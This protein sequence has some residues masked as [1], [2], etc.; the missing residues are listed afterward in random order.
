MKS[1]SYTRGDDITYEAM[2]SVCF[3][4]APCPYIPTPLALHIHALAPTYPCSNA[5][6]Y[7]CTHALAYYC[8]FQAHVHAL[9]PMSSCPMRPCLGSPM[10]D[11][12]EPAQAPA[13]PFPFLSLPFPS[14]IP[15][16]NEWSRIM[17]Q[18]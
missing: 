4:S 10:S 1:A 17:D 11:T 14:H 13:T 16:R 18:I 2:N 5:P 9:Y 8:I 15:S 3:K 7:P 6:T 12:V